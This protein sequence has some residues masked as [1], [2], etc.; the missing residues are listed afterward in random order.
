M[1]VS[2]YSTTPSLNSTISGTNIA[3]GC[4]PANINNAIRQIMADVKSFAEA[5]PLPA[6]AAASGAN[7]D[8]TSLRQ[9]VTVAATGTAGANTLGYRGLPLN[10][11]AGAY[12][13]V[14]ADQGGLV[15][16]STG[17]VTIPA[18]GTT[19]FPIGT[20]IAV[21]NNSGSSQTVG[22]TT[23]TLRLAGTGSTGTRTLAARGLATL[24]KVAATEWVAAGNVT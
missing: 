22:I 3:E 8:I 14:L 6:G 1:P 10:A 13:L 23:D 9:S 16:V 4:P 24:V 18:N 20:T 12:T 7:A 5:V 15:S 2:D 17:G 21:Y 19:A 11:P